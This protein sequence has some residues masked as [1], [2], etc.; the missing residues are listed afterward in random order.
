MKIKGY[1]CTFEILTASLPYSYGLVREGVV[2]ANI[3]SVGVGRG[4]ALR[5]PPESSFPTNVRCRNMLS[6]EAAML[7]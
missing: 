1:G 4:W 2:I 6:L 7:L 3:K 5:A